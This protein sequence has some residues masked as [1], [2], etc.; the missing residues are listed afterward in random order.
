MD[1]PK[2]VP[3]VGL[4]NGKFID[5]D[6]IAGT[7]G[8]LI[9]SV[10]G[11]AVTLEILKVI[12]EAGL[13]PDEDDNTQLN[14]AI[15]QKIS[16][17]SVA[18]AS[19]LEAEAGESTTKAMSPLRVFQA[20]AKVVTPATEIAFGWL[21]IATQG[22]VNAGTD[23]AAAITA[24]KIAAAVQAQAHT[25][26]TTAGTAAA[27][28]LTP[29]PAIPAYAAPQRF[30]VKF[31]QNSTPTSTINVSGKG[32]KPLKQ[33][34]ASGAKV[35]A[36]YVVDQLGDIEYD[37]ADFVLLDQLPA[38]NSTAP[39]IVSFYAAST[40]PDGY[41]KANG[42][43]VSRTTYAALFAVV[44][45]NYGPGDGSTTFRL[46]DLRGEFIRGWDDGR[47][48]DVGRAF[49]TAQADEFKSHV[50]YVPDSTA[51]G[52]VDGSWVYANFGNGVTVA[53]NYTQ[54]AGGT[55]TRPRN[56]ALLACIKY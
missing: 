20:I 55:E 19:Q 6:A 35:P 28:T 8:S 11:N 46:P 48:I 18:F 5:E 17:S 56:I 10:W 40:P 2:S 36:V 31:S 45:V 39:G 3:G 41:L 12:Q 22:Q 50:H 13:D 32:G 15:N 43:I 26:F 23:D 21:K 37:G 7:P 24:K 38:A 51:E 29:V 16:E 54:G 42:A 44:G 49:A 30:R 52:S 25:A 9:P 33:Y 1:F 4:V 14:A 27:L 34:D 53:T 47:G